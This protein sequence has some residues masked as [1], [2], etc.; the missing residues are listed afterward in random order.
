MLDATNASVNADIGLK[1]TTKIENNAPNAPIRKCK[2]AERVK[3]G[4]AIA[5]PF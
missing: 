3:F 1:L 5:F 4:L 2:S